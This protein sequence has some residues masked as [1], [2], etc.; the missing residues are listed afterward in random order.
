MVRL[1]QF[2]KWLIFDYAHNLT[3]HQALELGFKASVEAYRDAP[4]P[5]AS[6]LRLTTKPRL[7]T[8]FFWNRN[9]VGGQCQ[10]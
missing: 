2:K 8:N 4:Q 7:G 5:D 3:R 10:V 6:A 9:R 1:S